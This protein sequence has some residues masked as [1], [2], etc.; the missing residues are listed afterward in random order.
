[1]YTKNEID[2]RC[3]PEWY[4]RLGLDYAFC[5]RCFS[6]SIEVG[7]EFRTFFQTIGRLFYAD[8]NAEGASFN[9]Y[10]NINFH[11]LYVALGF[12]Y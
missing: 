10:K 4:L 6:G 9:D 1:M 2:W 8:D 3:I 5:Y 11:G 12:T 7:Y